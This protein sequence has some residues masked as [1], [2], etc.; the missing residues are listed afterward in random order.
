MPFDL[1]V[2]LQ[3][4][5]Y[6]EIFAI[7]DAT[8]IPASKAGS[9]ARFSVELFAD[10]FVDHVNGRPMRRAFDGHTTLLR[11]GGALQGA[12]HRRQLRPS[13]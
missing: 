6:D 4:T 11:R 8:D 2:T 12:A 13:R 1:L 3:S 7:G 5:A 10:N 9:V